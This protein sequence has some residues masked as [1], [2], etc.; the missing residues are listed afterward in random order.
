MAEL[1]DEDRILVVTMHHIVADG[2]SMGILVQELTTCYQAYTAGRPCPLPALPIQ[3]ADYARWQADHLER[4]WVEPQLAY[5]R[6][7][8]AG[9]GAAFELPTSRPRPPLQ[10]FAGAVRSCIIPA[11]VAAALRALAQRE[12]ATLFMVM[13]AGFKCLLAAQTGRK[14]VTVG[15]PIAGRNHAQVESLIGFFINILVLRTGLDGDPSFREL[16]GRVRETTLGAYAHQDL[17]AERIA[18]ALHLHRDLGRPLIPVAFVLQNAPAAPLELDGAKLTPLEPTTDTAKIDLTVFVRERGEEIELLFEYSTDLFEDQAV[19]GMQAD[20]LALLAAAAADPDSRLSDLPAPCTRLGSPEQATGLAAIYERSNLTMNQLLVWSGQKLQATVPIYNIAGLCTL[21][22]DIDR[23]HFQ[24]AFRKLV[25][26]CD[27]LRT[28]FHEVDGIPMQ[29]VLP[30]TPA[31]AESLDWSNLPAAGDRVGPWALQRCHRPFDLSSCLYDCV[32]I[33]TAPREYTWYFCHHHLITDGWSYMLILRFMSDLYERSVRGE[34]GTAPV[35]PSFQD[36]VAQER[37]YRRSP[38]FQKDRHYWENKF[39]E[40]VDDITFYGR[41]TLKHGSRVERVTIDLGSERSARI[42]EVL[43]RLDISLPLLFTAVIFVFL[44]CVAGGSAVSIGV[45]FHN[46]RSRSLRGVIGLLMEAVLL[47]VRLR[48]GETF[49]SLAAAAKAEMFETIRHGSYAIG[50]PRHRNAYDIFLNYHATSAELVNEGTMTGFAGATG[51]VK[52]VHTGHDFN[53]LAIHIHDFEASGTLTMDFD[54]HTDVFDAPIRQR[55]ID[56]CLRVLD[57]LLADP[58]Q[59]IRE[60]SLLSESER[61]HTL[62][63]LNQTGRAYQPDVCLHELIEEQAR[64]TPDATALAFE[65][66]SLTYRE[67]NERSDQLAAHLQGL[68][69]G[70]ESLVGICAERSLDMM[71]GL[72]GIL[73]SGGAYVPIDPT[74]PAER[75]A[76]MLSD[77]AVPVLLTQKRLLGQLPP[78]NARAI[79]LDDDLGKP[80]VAAAGPRCVRP[81]N[82]AYMIYTS[83][84]TGQPKGAMNTHRAIVNRLRWMQEQYA[85]TSQDRVLQKTPFSFDVSVWEF[86]WPLL[87][88]ATLVIARPEGHKDAAYL[89]RTIQQQSV[90][91]IHFV[92]SMLDVFLAAD[93]ADRCRSLKRVICSGE[94]LSWELTQRFRAALGAEL[95]NLYGPTEA[96]VDVTHWPCSRDAGDRVVPIGYP[97]ANTRI[98]ILDERMEPVPLGVRGELYIG[99]IQVGRGY[100]GRP[101]L[102]AERFVPDPFAPAGGARLYRTGDAG[103]HREDGSVECLGRLDNQVKIRGFR[104]ELGEIESRL[105]EHPAVREAAVT[106]S[107]SANGEKRLVGYVVRRSESQSDTSELRAWLRDRLP[108]YMVPAAFMELDRLPLSPNGKLDRK[109][110]PALQDTQLAGGH[111]ARVAPRNPLERQLVDLWEEMLGV[112][113]IGVTDNFFDLG[114]HS[115]VAVRMIGMLAQQTEREIPVAALFESPTIE[116]LAQILSGSDPARPPSPLVPIQPRGHHPPLFCVHA[117]FGSVLCFVEL[118]RSLGADQ[119]FFGLESVGLQGDAEPLTDIP[120]MAAAYVEAMRSRQPRGPYQLGGYSMGG[121]IAYEMAHQLRQAGEQVALLALFDSYT[122]SAAGLDDVRGLSEAELLRWFLEDQG[123]WLS[124]HNPEMAQTLKGLSPDQRIAHLLTELQ[125]TG[126]VPPHISPDKL[127]RYLRVLNGNLQAFHRYQP[128]PYDGRVVFVR[129]ADGTGD[130]QDPLPDWMRLTK[131]LQVIRVPGFHG[132]MLS[133]PHVREA[134][135]QLKR[136]LTDGVAIIPDLEANR[137]K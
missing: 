72:L 109:A 76:Y 74:Y 19:A 106:L 65:N 123:G 112:S 41:S 73:K 104:V 96:A 11:D 127:D 28:V 131:S 86:F 71:V 93:V 30:D 92:P 133:R 137:A 110:L 70:P 105:R 53:S 5:W 60:I 107:G 75:I 22:G 124:Q 91:T 80:P 21:R 128:K 116:R 36:Y 95:H 24:K 118:A 37:E 63:G 14:D 81:D 58:E 108:E 32:L 7:R 66:E 40:P 103:R 120:S 83:G 27:A 20:Y 31:E 97:L 1:S 98:Y 48:A 33:K 23:A 69:I 54:F 3:Y 50:N 61:V 43:T 9:A 8:L 67:L 6:E 136:I 2:W 99:G 115:L 15:S 87:T 130:G 38:R 68:G 17:P 10:T 49:R 4:E 44:H 62:R 46:R 85:L 84:S 34:L 94:A 122:P 90:T 78:H 51:S 55:T 111:G 47:R 117:L 132:T 134:A 57:L 59:P 12:Q 125:S 35:P 56:H 26:C 135:A 88:G 13:L 114:G 77:S 82:L 29:K 16:V 119:P 45:P 39:A 102:T 121:V 25:A 101:E 113:P 79:C 126:H 42:K 64:R 89:A 129:S 52:W 100:W 18:E